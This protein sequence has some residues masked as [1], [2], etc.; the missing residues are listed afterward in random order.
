[1]QSERTFVAGASRPKVLLIGDTRT[2]GHQGSAL[3]V[4]V[5]LHEFERRGV[6]V[7]SSRAVGSGFDL[8]KLSSFDGVVI[9][10]E[11]ALHVRSPKALLISRVAR[12][13]REIGIPC[14]V[15]NGVVDECEEEVIKGFPALTAVF[16]R[17][18]R[19]LD[20]ARS[21]GAS[22][23]LCPDVTLSIDIPANLEWTPGNKVFVTD[24]TL[25]SANRTLHA[26]A[27]RTHTPFLPMRTRPQM[28]LFSSKKAFLRIMK[29]EVRHKI[30]NMVPGSF[31]ADRFGC[32]VGSP[33][34][35]LRAIADGTKLIV[36]GRFHGVCL[37][38]RL[39]VPFLAVRTITHKMEGLLEDAQLSHKLIDMDTVKS[40]TRLQA[41]FA[42]GAWSDADETRRRSYVASAEKAIA[43]CFDEVAANISTRHP[44]V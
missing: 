3:V 32:A 43:A 4:Q 18:R 19:S 21:Y 5:I 36:S 40:T 22:A 38:M 16:C 14:F 12:Q 6:D 30:G 41:L 7:I 11:G 10:G 20:R 34:A 44:L 24:S 42:L 23:K 29:Y 8:A 39:G 2:V 17:E 28:P 31:T 26:F 25:N 33:D 27:R 35:F 9:N 13:A 37:A 15:L 1:M